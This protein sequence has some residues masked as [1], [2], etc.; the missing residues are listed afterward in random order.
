L[1]A[2]WQQLGSNFNFNL[3]ATWQQLG[4]NLAA[5]AT[6]TATWQ[7]LVKKDHKSLFLK[8]NTTIKTLQD[9]VTTRL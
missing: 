1:A 4:S 2:T 7:Q 9:Y 6:A 5:T 3:A 8:I